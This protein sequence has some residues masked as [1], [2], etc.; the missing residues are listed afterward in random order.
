MCIYVIILRQTRFYGIIEIETSKH[1]EWMCC[2]GEKKKINNNKIELS[3]TEPVQALERNQW[4]KKHTQHNIYWIHSRFHTVCKIWC[5]ICNAYFCIVTAVS[6]QNWISV[7]N[8]PILS[9]HHPA[10]W[11]TMMFIHIY[12]PSIERFNVV[13]WIYHQKIDQITFP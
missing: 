6:I 12:K 3:Q 7:R 2:D 1:I 10:F 5:A 8:F 9:H 13:N 11:W 4:K